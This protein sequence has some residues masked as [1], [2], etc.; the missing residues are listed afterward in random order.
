MCLFSPNIPDPKMP[1]RYAQQR[2]PDGDLV[3]DSVTRRQTDRSRAAAS[4]ILT[5]GSGVT[6]SAATAQKTLLGQ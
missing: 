3:R 2:Q 5:S 1:P 6:S 4:T